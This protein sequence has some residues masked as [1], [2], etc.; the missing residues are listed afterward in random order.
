MGGLGIDEKWL[1]IQGFNSN[2]NTQGNQMDEDLKC[3]E[4][5]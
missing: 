4:I 3:C 2:C 1:N 5:L